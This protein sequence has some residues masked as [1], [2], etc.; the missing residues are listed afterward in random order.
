MCYISII[1]QL[2]EWE[3][4]ISETKGK[5]ENEDQEKEGSERMVFKS[6]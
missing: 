4:F 1:Q 6:I 3:K 2:S 5:T